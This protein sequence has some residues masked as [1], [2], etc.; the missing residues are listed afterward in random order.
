MGGILGGGVVFKTKQ[1]HWKVFNR[2]MKTS[3]VSFRTYLAS[4]A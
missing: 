3:L 2:D 4:I 1:T